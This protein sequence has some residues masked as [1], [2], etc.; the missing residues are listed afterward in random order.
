MS[1]LLRPTIVVL[2][3]SG[4][5][6]WELMRTLAPLG[7]VI[8]LSRGNA[9]H[10]V[11][12][13]RPETIREALQA[14]RPAVIVNAAAYTAVDRAESERDLAMAVNATAPRVMAEEARYL[15]ALLLHYSTDYVFDGHGSIPYVETDTTRPLNVYG[16][17]KRVGEEAIQESAVSYVI[18]RTSWIYGLRGH[19]FLRTIMRVAQERDDLRIVSD[20]TGSPTWSRLVAEATAPIVA[21]WLH[22]RGVGFPASGVY[23]LSCAGQTNWCEFARAIIDH[24]R[25]RAP[26]RARAVQAITTAEYPTPA[27]RPS[28]SVLSNAKIHQHHGIA[29]PA[30]STALTLCLEALG[31]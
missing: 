28:Y 17:S 14:I 22:S 6:G 30:W 2:G 10:P 24:M 12:L 4:Q 29:L 5:I 13:A 8:G 23:H 18:L 9:D 15:G 3:P 16:L 11:D 27:A 21:R 31:T 20:Q 7:E 19:N 1:S 26:L 25:S